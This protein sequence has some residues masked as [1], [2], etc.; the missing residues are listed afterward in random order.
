MKRCHLGWAALCLGFLLTGCELVFQAGPG[1]SG[2]AREDYLKSIKPYLQYWEKPGWTPEGRR[3]DSVD[4]GSRRDIASPESACWT[5]SKCP[6]EGDRVPIF[7]KDKIG[8]SKKPGET[9]LQTETRLSQDWLRCMKAKGY[10]WV[11]P[12]YSRK[13]EK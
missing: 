9:E 13:A 8:A 3:G 7:G 12:D 10:Y 11:G 6:P 1:L 4:C 5:T 2:Q